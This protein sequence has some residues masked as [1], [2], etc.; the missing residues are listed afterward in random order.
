[1]SQ[2]LVFV[3]RVTDVLGRGEGCKSY[4]AIYYQCDLGMIYY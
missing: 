3:E 2:Y 1:M 4:S